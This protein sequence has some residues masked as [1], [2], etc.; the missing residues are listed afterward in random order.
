[1]VFSFLDIELY[2]MQC[3]FKKLSIYALILYIF[4]SLEENLLYLW[5]LIIF[6]SLSSDC[7]SCLPCCLVIPNSWTEI[8]SFLILYD[9]FVE[10]CIW[11]L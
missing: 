4:E 9:R 2:L 8:R 6:Q 5:E 11:A 3:L 10:W 7:E 1:M